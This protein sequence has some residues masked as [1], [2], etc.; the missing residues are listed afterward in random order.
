MIKFDQLLFKL[1]EYY[2]TVKSPTWKNKTIG[3]CY[4]RITYAFKQCHTFERFRRSVYFITLHT[5]LYTP[6][7]KNNTTRIYTLCLYSEESCKKLRASF[8]MAIW[9]NQF[10]NS[11]IIYSRLYELLHRHVL[12]QE[13]IQNAH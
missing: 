5:N 10:S 4:I 8:D 2:P 7:L 12:T 1:D 9:Q 11:N 3:E 13:E 6:L